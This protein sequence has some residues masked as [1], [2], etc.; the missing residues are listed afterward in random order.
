MS[1][2]VDLDQ[3][4]LTSGGIFVVSKK[5]ELSFLIKVVL[6]IRV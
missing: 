3:V 6:L 4:V 2:R 5:Q 1:T